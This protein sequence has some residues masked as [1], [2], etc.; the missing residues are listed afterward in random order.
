MLAISFSLH[1]ADQ[2]PQSDP[3]AFLLRISEAN[4]ELSRNG[5]VAGDCLLVLPDGHFHLERRRSQLPNR[6][7]RAKLKVFEF[8]LSAKQLQQLQ[9]ILDEGTVQ[10]LPS[11][12]APVYPMSSPSSDTF[13]ATIARPQKIQKVGFVIWRGGEPGASPNF[14]PK[15]IKQ[16]WH[17]SEI[18]L[19]PLVDWLHGL[20]ATK[21]PRHG[22]ST[23]CKLPGE[24]DDGDSN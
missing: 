8:V 18:S 9:E 11:Y 10:S 15:D 23:L 14:T 4:I 22:K 2:S 21:L 17:D 6:R 12:T 5:I 7:G 13:I 20:E 3:A 24:C 16:A 1:A 19:R